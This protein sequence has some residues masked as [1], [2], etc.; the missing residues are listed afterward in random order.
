VAVGI[1]GIMGGASSEI[2]DTTSNVLL[3]AA[4]FTP[5][6][7]ARTSQRLGLRTEASA[8]FERGCDPDGIE[9]AV[10]RFL[11]LLGRGDVA[12]GMLDVRSG[13]PRPARIRLRTGRVNAL[14][15][16]ALGDDEVRSYL[17]PIG[18]R[19]TSAGP[20]LH[21][22]VPP[23]FRPDATTEID[24]VE[25]VAR[26]HGYSRIARTVPRSP[27]V[28]ALTTYQRERRRLRD[29]LVGAGLG[30]A[31]TPP[32][33]APGDHERAGLSGE[34]IVAVD[35]LAREE[36]VLRTS[37]LPGLLK[38]VAFNV[39]H[40]N[41]V[42]SLFE[43]GHVFGIPSDRAAELPDEREVVGAALAGG[44]GAPAAKRL[45]DVV[46]DGLGRGAET[47]LVAAG[48]PGLHPTRTAAVEIAGRAA[49]HVGEVDPEVAAA[50]GV[51]DRVGWL[52]LDL[53]VLLRK[54]RVYVQARPLSR[55]PSSDIDLAFVVDDSTAAAEVEA[56]LRRSAGD[57]LAGLRL[58]DVFRDPRLGRG[59]RSLAFRL[60]LQ[61]LDHTLTDGEIAEVR[62][63]CIDAVE[64]AHAAQLRG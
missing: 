36:S 15:G 35:P 37:L 50:F 16:T 31:V 54:Q 52:Y 38:A 39:G 56:T 10:A 64:K 6:A 59:R 47:S 43:V 2:S 12:P 62:S 1:G 51:E 55:L 33:L 4:Y 57:L 19:T 61:S 8:R 18:F 26:H 20:G 13:P 3:E 25:E 32:M 27:Q 40:R 49:G 23:T 44:E 5:M 41:P 45:L 24:L 42:V 58:F 30:E 11:S 34:A 48:A 9:R 7:I 28:G 21:E 63:R 17:E 53:D 14:L 29:V 46:L 60:C 22:V